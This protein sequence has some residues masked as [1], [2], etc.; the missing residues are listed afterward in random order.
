MNVPSFIV[1]FVLVIVSSSIHGQIRSVPDI[2]RSQI[3]YSYMDY[4]NA[5]EDSHLDSL[6]S[7]ENVY[8]IKANP[9][10][11]AKYSLKV[12]NVFFY[13]PIPTVQSSYQNGIQ[14]IQRL[15]HIIQQ[16]AVLF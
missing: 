10:V 5:L 13:P 16:V 12:S 9:Q 3:D 14:T 7:T 2:D 8:L 1:F 15:I 11:G 4:L 6:P